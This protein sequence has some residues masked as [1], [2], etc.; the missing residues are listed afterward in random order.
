MCGTSRCSGCRSC[1]RT[2]GPTA[3]RAS[4]CRGSASTT[5]SGPRPTYKRQITNIGYYWAASDYFDLTTRFDWL[6]GRYSTLA[7][8]GQYRWLDRFTNGSIGISRQWAIGW[9]S[10]HRRHL[11]P[12][13]G[14]FA[15]QLAQPLAEL[16]DEQQHRAEQRDRPAPDDPADHQR[17]ELHPPVHLG[18]PDPGRQSQAEHREQQPDQPAA[19]H[20]PEPEAGEHRANITWSPGLSFT[21]DWQQKQPLSPPTVIPLP[22]GSSDTLSQDAGTPG[23]P[24]SASRRR[25]A[26]GSFTWRNS[27]ARTPTRRITSATPP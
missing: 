19:G 21:T 3:T 15:Q 26:S 1:S 11:G 16:R 8:F 18:N 23:P 25:S 20:H 22:G 9:R 27:R 6:D 4:W 5:S 24:P 17:L 13:P 14:L 12:P 2:G 7:F 10:L